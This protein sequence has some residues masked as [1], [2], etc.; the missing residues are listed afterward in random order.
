MLSAAVGAAIL[1][2]APRFARAGVPVTW[3]ANT[4]LSGVQGGSGNWN[5]SA[6]NWDNAG[7]P[8][9][10]FNSHSDSAVFSG[11]P[12][13]TVQLTA[14][15]TAG[16]LRFDAAGY[17]IG[18]SLLLS[19][20]SDAVVAANADA[21]ISAPLSTAAGLTKSGAGTLTLLASNTIR[22]NLLLLG[23]LLSFSNEGQLGVTAHAIEMSGG[24]MRYGGA[25]SLTLAAART[26]TIDADGGR[27]D[28]PTSG[29]TLGTAG[30][31]SGVGTLAKTG[32]QTLTITAA[33]AGFAGTTDVAAGTL[34]LQNAGA[35]NGRPITLSGGA[36]F[37]RGDQPT[38]FQSDVTVTGD[39]AMDVDHVTTEGM[40]AGA[41]SLDDL[42]IAAGGKLAVTGAHQNYLTVHNLNVAGALRVS[43]AALMVKG[44]LAGGGTIT[45][46]TALRAPEFFTSGLLFANGAAQTIS[47]P[48]L[49]DDAVAGQPIVGIAAGT[50]LTY[51]G[52]WSGGGASAT[53]S[54]VLRDGATFIAGPMARLNTTTAD[55]AGQRPFVVIGN[56]SSNTFDLDAG[57]VADHTA[58]GTV[59]DGFSWLEVRDATLITRATVGLPAVVKKDGFGGTHRAGGL[60]FSGTAGARWNVATADQQYD[61]A[62]TFNS[63]ATLQADRDLTHVGSVASKFD[64]QFQIPIAGVAVTKQGAGWLNLSGSQGYVA[65]SN[66]LVQAGGVRFNTD[67]GAGWYAG[68]F[69]RGADGNISTAPKPAGTLTVIAGGGGG[70]GA[71]GATVEFAALASHI[72]A[73]QVNAGGSARVTAGILVTRSMTTTGGGQVDVGSNRLVVDYD[74]TASPLVDMAAMIKGGFNAGGPSWQGGGIVSGAAAANPAMGVGYAEA[75]DVLRLTGAQTATFGG[76][77]VDATSVLVRLTRMGD[78]DLDGE[79]GFADF[80]RMERGFGQTGQT[81]ASGDFNYD[82]KVDVADFK[83]LYDNYGQTADIAAPEPAGVPEPSAITFICVTGMTLLRRRRIGPPRR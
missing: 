71:A 53:S 34:W 74:G 58:G 78:A 26:L 60:T 56:G 40:S 27:I 24:G 13:G 49:A 76:Q 83:L 19:L 63:S 16:G 38:A 20:T 61:G 1:S 52:P 48:I 75:A 65:G 31:L 39:A 51:N 37:L 15:I 9:P 41:H 73:L 59:A 67:P 6:S 42:T 45:F 7:V 46:G 44:T 50:T 69:T 25:T 82:G 54:I 77:S 81:W 43:N 2:L 28:L 10:W 29:M 72:D 14:A 17:T 8:G 32:A 57:V 80:Q 68:N 70:G 12:G 5:T 22:A 3:D 11:T 55:V 47:N 79:V 23:G 33:N 18:G 66:L 4:S 62:I 30:Q 35:V 36:L 21:S 64:G